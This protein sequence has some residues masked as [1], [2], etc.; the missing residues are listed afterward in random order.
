MPNNAELLRDPASKPITMLAA[1]AGGAQTVQG[2]RSA[3]GTILFANNPTADDTITINGTVFTFKDSGATGNQIN[4][5]A[6]LVDTVNNAVTVLNGSAVAGVAL[7]TYANLSNTTLTVTYDVKGSAGN[8]FTLAAS[9]D[10]PSGAT[11]TGGVDGDVL[12]IVDNAKINLVT[13]AGTVSSFTLPDSP[14]D[15]Q[16][17]TLV[18]TSKGAGS[19]AAVSGN[20]SGANVLAT[21]DT[22]GDWIK[23]GWIGGEWATIVNSNVVLS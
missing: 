18:L 19:N 20:L 14:Y 12:S 9:S 15:Y 7:A 8:A 22:V 4:I 23:L 3:Y 5:G 11:L 21:F 16:E 6:A 2:S 10:T 17:V 13:A 1:G